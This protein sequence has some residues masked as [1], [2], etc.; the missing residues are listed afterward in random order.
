MHN[1]EYFTYPENVK[2]DIVQKEL[3]HVVACEDYKEGCKGLGQPIRWLENLGICADY[4]SAEKLLRVNDRGWYDQLAVRFYEPIP[5]KGK[6][7]DELAERAQ[8]AGDAY[9]KADNAVW[10]SGFKSEYVGCRSCGSKLKRELLR[11][12]LC[13]VCRA[14]L[15]PDSTLKLIDVARNK[16]R[17]AQMAHDGYIKQHAKKCVKW[18]VKIEY[19][20]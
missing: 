19:H 18:L 14:D 16:W 11:T 17:L 4:E 12:N 20:T 7:V 15:R 6:A 13:P 1:I 10:A 9:R 2:K 3:D 8:K 5:F